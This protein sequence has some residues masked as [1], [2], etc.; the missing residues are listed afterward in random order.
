LNVER[1]NVQHPTEAEH[2]TFNV[3]RSNVQRPSGQLSLF[4]LAPNPVVE[5]IRRLNINDL[6]PLEALNKL[7]ELQRLA[8]RGEG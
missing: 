8:G 6:T 5:L 2:S 4:D 3:Q 7:A 1:S